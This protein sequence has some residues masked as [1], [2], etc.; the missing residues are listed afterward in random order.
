[1]YDGAHIWVADGGAGTLLKLDAAGA[2][3]Q[4]VPVGSDPVSLAFDGA[5]IWVP[6]FLSNSITVVQASSGAIVATISQDASNMLDGPLAASFDGERILVTNTNNNSVTVFKAADLS[7]VV[8]VSTGAGSN[9]GRA[10]S[11]GINFWIP[12]SN[13]LLRF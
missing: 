12:S 9:P 7:V 8:N 4:T 3:L 1:V 5:N 11:D 2:I 13:G 10:C 6:N